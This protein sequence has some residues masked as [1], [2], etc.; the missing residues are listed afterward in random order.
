MRRVVLPL[1]ACLLALA[2]F[3]RP[4]V[5]HSHGSLTTTVLF[6]REIV[7]ILN[8]HCVMCHSEGSLSFP[9]STYEETWVRGRA[10]RMAVLRR[11]MPPWAAV[12]GYGQF[13]NDNSFTLRETQFLVSWVE[14]LGPRNAGG[15]F[16]NVA[17]PGAAPPE[18]RASAHVGHWMGGTPSLTR[19]LERTIVDPGRG[20]VVRRTT[21]DLGLP[22]ERSLR[23]VEYMP[24]DRRVVRAATFSVAGSGQWIGSWTPWQGMTMLPADAAIRLPARARV[25]AELHYR[26]A[27][28]AVDDAGTLGLY[29]ADDRR[30]AAASDLVL[31]AKPAGPRKLRASARLT[32]NTRVWAIR[33]EIVPG[34]ASVEVSA[35]TP[36]GGKQILLLARSPAPEWPTPFIYKE[37]VLLPRG[38]EIAVVAEIAQGA[39]APS[40]R[41]TIGRY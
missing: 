20:D 30:T 36:D 8:N 18:V 24:G 37:P 21:I 14:G 19:T 38:S 25:V 27:A 32:A 40:V 22:S 7:R 29:F 10:I 5:A 12:P 26:S 2:M 34:L 1:A 6:D 16:L 11:H 39:S 15:V 17:R 31:E 35:R 4:H 28:E 3:G 13:A 41:V 23:G 33:P 9:L